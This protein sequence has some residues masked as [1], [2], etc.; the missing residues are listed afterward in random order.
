MVFCFV[1]VVQGRLKKN[2]IDRV[3]WHFYKRNELKE[4]IVEKVKQQKYEENVTKKE[5]ELLKMFFELNEKKSIEQN[6]ENFFELLEDNLGKLGAKL[7][8]VLYLIYFFVKT[9]LPINEQKDYIEFTLYTLK[10]TVIYFLPL[11]LLAFYIC[12]KNLNKF[13]SYVHII[14]FLS[15]FLQSYLQFYRTDALP[16]L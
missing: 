11:F 14:Y 15:L 5:E 8:A 10:P 9:I 4:K 16:P 12:F 1:Q 2:M 3:Q 6:I 7:V 13:I